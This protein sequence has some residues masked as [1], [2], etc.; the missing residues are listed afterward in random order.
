MAHLQAR[1]GMSSYNVLIFQGKYNYST[2]IIIIICTYIIFC[3]D[4]NV[5][6]FEDDGVGSLVRR[7]QH[8]REKLGTR[9][10]SKCLKIQGKWNNSCVIFFCAEFLL[11]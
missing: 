9:G 5:V 7:W 1:P 11:V 4:E 2:T 8:V 10:L 3:V 6:E